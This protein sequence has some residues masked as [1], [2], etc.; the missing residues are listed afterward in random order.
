[1]LWGHAAKS[2]TITLGICSNPLLLK[3]KCIFQIKA[4]SEMESSPGHTG[5]VW[6][7]PGDL[8]VLKRTALRSFAERCVFTLSTQYNVCF[9]AWGTMWSAYFT[10]SPPTPLCE[11]WA[12]QSPPVLHICPGFSVGG[13][14][15]CWSLSPSLLFKE[16]H[17]NALSWLSFSIPAPPP[18]PTH[19]LAHWTWCLF[20]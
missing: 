14:Y 7:L 9:F 1:M 11:L 2:P 3:L 12:K 17:L 4:D 6:V 20:P 10:N 8:K 19:V 18:S 13:E 5:T 16:I 15:L